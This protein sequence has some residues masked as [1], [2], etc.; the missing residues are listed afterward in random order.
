MPSFWFT[1]SLFIL[2]SSFFSSSHTIEDD[3]KLSLIDFLQNLSGN[4]SDEVAKSFGWT[5]STDPCTD[6]W[7]G[8]SCNTRTGTL[9]KIIL[10]GKGFNGS[11]DARSLCKA[12]RLA[13]VS[14]HHNE[15][16]GTLSPEISD[17]KQ[18]THLLI[19]GNKLSGSLPSSLSGLNNLKRL[20]ISNNIF[21]GE[22]PDLP[23]ISG[24]RTF[25]AH[26]NKLSGSIPQLDFKNLDEFNISN[27]L[28]IGNIPQDAAKF[29]PGSLSG[30]PGL[31]GE[32]LKKPCQETL[33]KRKSKEISGEKLA[34]IIGYALLGFL[35]ILLLAF[36]IYRRRK[37]KNSVKPVNAS[38]TSELSE[39][40]S[41]Y[42][43]GDDSN[44]ASPVITSDLVVLK[45]GAI[46]ELSF[47]NLLKAPA[48]L[49]AKSKVGSTYKVVLEEGRSTFVV[50]RVKDLKMLG[51][52]FSKRMA[53]IDKGKHESVLPAVAF[54]CS[55]QEKLVLYEYQQNGSIINLL[56]GSGGGEHQP[57]TGWNKRLDIAAR[58]ANGLAF[59]HKEL[60]DREL[61]HGN[62]KSTNILLDKNMNPLISEYGLT[63]QSETKSSFMD[64]VFNLGVILLELL[65]GRVVQNN[66]SE[67]AQWVQ[68]VVKEEWTVEVFDKVLTGETA[69]E[70][71]MVS[72]LQVALL[73]MN[74]SL[75]TRPSMAGVASMINTLRDEEEDRS[76]VSEV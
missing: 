31:C 38:T 46:P 22:L 16:Q 5:I 60:E 43:I 75:D 44:T 61:G 50:K 47:E 26:D 65:T 12:T 20:D 19:N 45:S 68:S 35:V 51:K 7:N 73:C 18:L 59:M 48:E 76:I 6:R 63:I 30:N 71:A 8:V 1:F 42:S 29:G 72:L 41:P 62:L 74:S 14:L 36:M 3:I 69:S 2:I 55:K 58:V 23:S 15:L 56:Q 34:M 27:N 21:S 53:M 17:C 70:E 64:D 49:L 4:N 32:P 54:Y 67:L 40:R 10:E 28:F 24:L 39:Q 33:S 37:K 13:V 57:L 25:L 11:I 9:R 52:D 66:G